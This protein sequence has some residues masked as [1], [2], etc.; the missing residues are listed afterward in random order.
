[1]SPN[2]L[3]R[4][5]REYRDTP[6][7][8]NTHTSVDFRGD[9]TCRFYRRDEGSD[10]GATR[11]TPRERTVSSNLTKYTTES[12]GSPSFVPGG[13]ENFRSKFHRC[14]VPPMHKTTGLFYGFPFPCLKWRVRPITTHTRVPSSLTSVRMKSKGDEVE[15]EEF[16]LEGRI[17][18]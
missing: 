17:K 18:S 15:Q 16:D 1:M 5:S 10:H 13:Q 9:E 11:G 7:T 14:R 8:E 2:L 6:R 3:L 4:N 12:H